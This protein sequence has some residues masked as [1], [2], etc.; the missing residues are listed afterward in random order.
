VPS[1][2]QPCASSGISMCIP[3]GVVYLVS[4]TMGVGL[5]IVVSGDGISSTLMTSSGCYS[6]SCNCTCALVLTLDCLA[7]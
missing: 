5:T 6:F 2:C 4:S 1:F 3:V 7:I